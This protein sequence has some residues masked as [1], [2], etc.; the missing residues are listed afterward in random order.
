MATEIE[1]GTPHRSQV[2]GPAA[3]PLVC[4]DSGTRST[5]R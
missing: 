5:R 2:D 3:L 4:S 1:L